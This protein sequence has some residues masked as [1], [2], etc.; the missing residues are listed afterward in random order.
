VNR[1]TSHYL[2]NLRAFRVRA[3]AEGATALM[4]WR[5]LQWIVHCVLHWPATVPIGSRGAR[6]RLPAQFRQGSAALFMLRDRYEPEMKFVEQVLGEGMVFVDGGANLGIYTVFASALV[7]RTGTVLSFEPG[8]LTYQRLQDNIALNGARNVKAHQRALSDTTGTA[9][10]YHTRDHFVSYS[11]ASSDANDVESEVTNTITIDQAV[12]DAWL[13]RVD[14]LK[15][16]V[17]GAEELALRGARK[18]LEQW[19]PIVLFE[20]LPEAPSAPGL[21]REGAWRLLRELDYRLF[22]VGDNGELISRQTPQIGNN[23]A[24]PPTHPLASP[25]PAPATA[26]AAG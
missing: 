20:V 10:L 17:A 8:G 26:T 19:S 6:L 14:F 18:T 13:A 15:L 12:S 3:R 2:P 23:V 4:T 1:V 24:L 22:I 25:V 9:R 16:D 7:G 5:L 21:E 11:L